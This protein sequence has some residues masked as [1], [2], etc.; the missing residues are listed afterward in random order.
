MSKMEGL[1]EVSRVGNASHG[2]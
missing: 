2:S 1:L